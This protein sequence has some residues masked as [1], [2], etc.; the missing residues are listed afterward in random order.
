MV[1]RETKVQLLLYILLH[2][3]TVSEM[4]YAGPRVVRVDYLFLSSVVRPKILE[5]HVHIQNRH[6]EKVGKDIG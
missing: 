6:D 5:Q 4:T 3:V 1:T 2:P